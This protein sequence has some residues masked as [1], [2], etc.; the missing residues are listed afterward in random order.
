MANTAVTSTTSI[1]KISDLRGQLIIPVVEE[2]TQRYLG[3]FR[4]DD[5]EKYKT[6]VST[7][8]DLLSRVDPSGNTR[9]T[10]VDPHD[11]PIEALRKIG[12]WKTDFL[13][14]VDHTGVYTGTVDIKGLS[15]LLESNS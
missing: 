15:E 2:T 13:P 7:C 1:Q 12:Q 14:L 11:S 5:V 3:F 6:E 4:Y 9:F 8:K 10:Y